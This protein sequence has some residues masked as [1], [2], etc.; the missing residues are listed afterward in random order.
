M[1][2]DLVLDYQFC[3]I[4]DVFINFGLFWV[5]FF[6]LKMYR[7]WVSTY[8]VIGAL[9]VEKHLP[10]EN[11]PTLLGMS[12]FHLGQPALNRWFIVL[13]TQQQFGRIS[14]LYVLQNPD[15]VFHRCYRVSSQI[16]S[17]LT[18]RYLESCC[19]ISPDYSGIKNKIVFKKPIISKNRNWFDCLCASFL[20]TGFNYEFESWNLY[21]L[22]PANVIQDNLSL[23]F[24]VDVILAF[25]VW[26]YPILQDKVPLAPGFELAA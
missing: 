7:I 2:G 26:Q 4:S 21:K 25:P 17:F 20:E 12:V 15:P 18:C 13:F 6:F 14:P 23:T 3:L 10:D 16:I 5:F 11:A 8:H 9:K 19:T 1:E 22:V 24:F